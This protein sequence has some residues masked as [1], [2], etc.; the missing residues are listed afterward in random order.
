M[1]CNARVA[2]SRDSSSYPL[3]V[4]VVEWPEGHQVEVR[5]Y[6]GLSFYDCFSVRV[7]KHR[8]YIG[9]FNGAVKPCFD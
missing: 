4:F 5:E 2:A 9:R 6:R 1:G 3:Q 7:G 8:F